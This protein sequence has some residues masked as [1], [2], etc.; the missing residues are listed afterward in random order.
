VVIIFLLAAIILVISFSSIRHYIAY[1]NSLE[2]KGY[3]ALVNEK[4]DQKTLKNKEVSELKKIGFDEKEINALKEANLETLTFRDFVSLL[5]LQDNKLVE[6]EDLKSIDIYQ[7]HETTEVDIVSIDVRPVEAVHFIEEG[8]S[9]TFYTKLQYTV[10]IK[11][12][13]ILQSREEFKI[14]FYDSYPLFEY[15]KLQYISSKGEV[16]EQYVTRKKTS[17]GDVPFEFK[18]KQKIDG[19]TYYLSGISGFSIM[20]SQ[21]RLS[22]NAEYSHKQFITNSVLGNHWSDWG[23]VYN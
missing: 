1:G 9:K 12:P 21:H 2:Y 20:K 17:S 7:L 18:V 11:K 3:N 5:E 8:G 10:D 4:N 13:M 16:N 19:N 6:S 22:L 14:M 15:V 23:W